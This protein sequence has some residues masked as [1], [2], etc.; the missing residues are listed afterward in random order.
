MHT[1]NNFKTPSDADELDDLDDDMVIGVI[2]EIEQEALN[3][4]DSEID[5][6]DL[7]DL[8][9]PGP[10]HEADE[11]ESISSDSSFDPNAED[12][13]S[14]DSMLEEDEADGASSG[15]ATS[16]K[17]RKA[18]DGPCGSSGESATFDLDADDE[19]DET[20]RAI[21]AAIKKPRSAPPEIK[22]ED[23]ITDVCFHPGRD[24]IALATIIGDVHLY[25]YGT[26]GNKLLRTIEVHSKACRDVEFTEDGRYL[27]TASKDK[28]VM[29]TDV[30]TEKLKKLYETAHDDAIN[31]L[32]VLDENL[33]ASGDDAGTVKLWDLRTKHPIFELKELED[34]IT[35]MI[36]NE[37]KKLLLATSADGYLT[38]FNIAARKLY[39]QSEPYEEELNCMGIYRANSKLV[40]GTSKG[41]L[42][43]YNWGSFGY[44]CDMYPGIKSPISLMI[45]ITDRIA[46][47]A[48]ED[49]NIRA[50]H[51]TPYRNL[52]VVG[53]HNMP[54]ESLDINTNGELLASSSHNNDVRFWN[55]KYFEDFGDIKYND[56]HNAYKEKRHNL[57]SSKCTNASDF[58][59]DLTK[60]DEDNED[61]NDASAG[62][63]NSA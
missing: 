56:K 53:Q 3:E 12:S 8:G 19:T 1:H 38:T 46:C 13:D 22:L 27:L 54:I 26:E 20:V 43:T 28:S 17:R 7:G 37:Q 15:G 6:D 39:V 62:P 34:Q 48:G 59:S 51:I 18:D 24:I 16:A 29:V 55:V 31:K 11:N 49:G 14:D 52:G 5:E 41:K 47:V 61:N 60:E 4:S 45:P 10:G 57:P 40:V 50:C 42:Y 36:T 32:Y 35:Q 63:S 30:E 33:F 21:I 9:V 25:E 2:E 23:F 44:H 58:F